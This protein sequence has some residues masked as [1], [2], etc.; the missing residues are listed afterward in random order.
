MPGRAHA[1][2]RACPAARMP[3][4]AHA[5]PRACPAARSRRARQCPAQVLAHLAQALLLPVARRAAAALFLVALLH[6]DGE[7]LAG[8]PRYPPMLDTLRGLGARVATVTARFEDGYRID[9]DDFRERLSP[10]TRLV[11]F[12]SPQNPSGVS[13]TREEIREMLSAMSRCCPEAVLLP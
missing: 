9:L 12:A 13:I 8:L 10:R 11:M 2:P 7:I 6:S 1:R 4:R 3:G 5:R